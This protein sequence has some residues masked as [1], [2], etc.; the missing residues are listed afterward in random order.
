MDPLIHTSRNLIDITLSL[1]AVSIAT[2]KNVPTLMAIYYV[3]NVDIKIKN[4][5]QSWINNMCA[6]NSCMNT[7]TFCKLFPNKIFHTRSRNSGS[8]NLRDAKVNSFT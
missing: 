6:D 1:C 2:I 3:D 7:T 4:M 8:P 5:T